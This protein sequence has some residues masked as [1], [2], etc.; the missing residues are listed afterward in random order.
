LSNSNPPKSTQS[1]SAQTG[2]TPATG[3]KALG[4][5]SGKNTPKIILGALI[6]V[7]A[8]WWTLASIETDK[9]LEALSSMDSFYITLAVLLTIVAYLARAFRWPVFFEGG[10]K[11]LAPLDSFRCLIV[12]FFMN[13]TLP[14]RMGELVR[15]HLGGYAANTSRSLV[16]ATI[17]GERLADGIAISLLF[18]VLFTW[19]SGELPSGAGDK[20]IFVSF[21]FLLAGL[22]TAACL[23]ARKK[24]FSF[25]E[26]L[27]DM[28]PGHLSSYSVKKIQQFIGGLEPMMQPLRLVKISAWSVFIWAIELVAYKYVTLA[29]GQELSWGI[30]G[31]FLA[32][33]NFS[34]LIPAAPGGIGV[35]EAIAT[36]SL[37]GVGVEREAALAMVAVQH[38]IQILVVGIPGAY[39]FFMQMQG[40]VPVAEEDETREEGTTILRAE[41]DVVAGLS[42]EELEAG[43]ECDVS[44]V[45]PAYNEEDRLPQTLLS[46]VEYCDARSENFEI[47]VVDDG[48]TD[49]TVQVVQRMEK[50]SP[51][52][53]LLT[54]E[55]NRG[56]GYAVRHGVLAAKGKRVLYS[57]ADGAT[58]IEELERLEEILKKDCHIAIGSRALYSKETSTKTVWYRK[59]IGRAFNGLVN[60]LILP[61]IAD[62]QC[63]FKLFY[64]KAAQDLFSLQSS[65]GF[66]FDV[67][68]LFLARRE[69]Y[70]IAEVPINWTNIPGS[71]VDLVRDSARMG[72]DIIKFRLRG[73]T[74]GYKKS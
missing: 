57:D 55:E 1:S 31:L 33:V 17:A 58:P 11:A 22:M 18:G 16:L 32:V 52:V 60:F 19:F 25:L 71:K 30:I 24:V 7:L 10:T 26:Q 59:F 9:I 49:G 28:M 73:M 61:G 74:G 44:V 6:S 70:T 40:E 54:Y 62:T 14:A 51:M 66:S 41:G 43:S 69:G 39:Y 50:L 35:I 37:V 4:R 72:V 8:L 23:L 15:A 47:L 67:E 5:N 56:K 27:G 29:F 21:L 2:V 34:S 53:K 38:L 20:I 68:L 65:E 48:S 13:N 12:G 63:G 64:R 3:K 42:V 45:I 46:V 36:A